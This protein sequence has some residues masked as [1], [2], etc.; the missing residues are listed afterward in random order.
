MSLSQF[1]ARVNSVFGEFPGDFSRGCF[2]FQGRYA[3]REDFVTRLVR[4][5]TRSTVAPERALAR[6]RVDKPTGSCYII[7]GI[8]IRFGKDTIE[9]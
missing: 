9:L 5:S 7:D 8:S 4:D 1:L 6:A 3:L 2:R